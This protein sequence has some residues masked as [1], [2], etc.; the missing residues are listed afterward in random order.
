MSSPRNPL[1]IY[2]SFSTHYVLL[3]ARNTEALRVFNQREKAAGKN[4]NLDEL[5]R[6]K[7]GE[8]I[9][10]ENS[11][12][13]IYMVCDSRKISLFRI[14]SV[15]FSTLYSGNTANTSQIIDGSI[16]MK[17]IDSS[18]IAFINFLKY[19][20]DEVLGSSLVN[21]FFLLKIFF[22]GHT[23]DGKV[24]VLN[25]SSIPMMLHDMVFEF[26]TASNIG[27]AEYEI[28]F[29]PSFTPG[30]AINQLVPT[31]RISSIASRG[32]QTTLGNA[33]DSLQNALNKIN[34][35][36]YNNTQH[37]SRNEKTQKNELSVPENKKGRLV[38]YKISLP[39][40]IPEIQSSTKWRD[41]PF[42][43]GVSEK[44][45][46]ISHKKT[47][48][49][50]EGAEEKSQKS[51]TEGNTKT[52]DDA[53]YK[54]V[55]NN[56]SIDDILISILTSCIEVNRRAAFKSVEEGKIVNFKI[57]KNMTTDDETVVLN[58]DIVEHI[59]INLTPDE[60]KKETIGVFEQYFTKN[61]K[62][63]K[64]P[65][66]S[67]EFD[68]VFSG[69]NT[70]ILDFA[71]KIDSSAALFSVMNKTKS[72]SDQIRKNDLGQSNNPDGAKSSDSPKNTTMREMKSYDMVIAPPKTVNEKMGYS[73][74]SEGSQEKTGVESDKLA[75]IKQEYLKVLAD[76]HGQSSLQT[77]MKIRGNPDLFVKVLG[78]TI[79]PHI[80]ISPGSLTSD[81]EVTFLDNSVKQYNEELAKRLNPIS[82]KS[83]NALL[84]GPD[85]SISPLFI[86]VNVYGPKIDP[87]FGN[88]LMPGVEKFV[89]KYFYE[90]WYMVRKLSHFLEG[91]NF[92]QEIDMQS[93]EIF[94]SALI[95]SENNK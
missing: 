38:L 70:D 23:H 87:I 67:L 51:E 10:T 27:A 82:P 55:P 14:N 88:E 46:E 32:S 25:T 39:G 31:D 66:N 54:A 72:T 7:L 19:M 36:Y 74:L 40:D 89:Q 34:K 16:I 61:D 49:L 11:G 81:K 65:K 18:G 79:M 71:I 63:E 59:I 84:S 3:L 2:A 44:I 8:K 57:L 42:T 45:K 95:K 80:S 1:D 64:V 5:T 92:I 24:E 33:I 20:A 9:Q 26:E 48:K 94:K 52:A 12:G 58:F 76:V 78:S 69:M 43:V 35:D 75:K 37:Q 93:T 90:D 85:F 30:S 4:L 91:N 86:K 77:K 53:V 60:T 6:L 21:C 73:N 56:M 62:G 29:T 83:E 47:A 13:D 17:L 22:V 15:N 28:K 41:L 50:N 68:Y